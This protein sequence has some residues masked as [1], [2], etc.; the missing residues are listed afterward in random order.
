MSFYLYT[1]RCMYCML[2]NVKVL[3]PNK[4]IMTNFKFWFYFC[5]QYVLSHTI[6][7]Y[8][9]DLIFLKII[10]K[11]LLWAFIVQSIS[12]VFHNFKKKKKKWLPIAYSC[13]LSIY[14]VN[15]FHSVNLTLHK[16]SSIQSIQKMDEK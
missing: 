9:F 5:L 7:F 13:S 1:K 12:V 15:V 11:L 2:F 8:V 6:S 14:I 10:P 3:C 16:V 4:I